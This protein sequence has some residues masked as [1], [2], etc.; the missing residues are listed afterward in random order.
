MLK[1]SSVKAS[2]LLVLRRRERLAAS[3]DRMVGWLLL[4]E[5][6]SSTEPW[7][8]AHCHNLKAKLNHDRIG[9]PSGCPLDPLKKQ[10]KFLAYACI[11][12]GPLR[13]PGY[14]EY[15]DTGYDT[16]SWVGWKNTPNGCGMESCW[17]FF[18]LVIISTWIHGTGIFTPHEWVD[19][20]EPSCW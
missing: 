1:L 16:T 20:Y 4:A 10:L 19:L 6:W 12:W 7:T 15:P 14:P 11:R 3:H 8:V 18:S 2:E 9:T 13:L 17:N 5:C